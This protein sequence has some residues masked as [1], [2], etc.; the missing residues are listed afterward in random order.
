M[1]HMGVKYLPD[2]IFLYCSWLYLFWASCLKVH[3]SA[4]FLNIFE[5]YTSSST[6]ASADLHSI[7]AEARLLQNYFMLILQLVSLLQRTDFSIFLRI[8]NV[9]KWLQKA[10]LKR[11]KYLHSMHNSI[12]MDELCFTWKWLRNF[13]YEINT[14]WYLFLQQSFLAEHTCRK[15]VW[16]KQFEQIYFPF[17]YILFHPI[18]VSSILF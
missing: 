4:F 13:R 18:I 3:I 14:C 2:K 12:K 6:I 5:I 17:N 10:F 9:F 1:V 15:I 11:L 16:Y 7:W 8:A